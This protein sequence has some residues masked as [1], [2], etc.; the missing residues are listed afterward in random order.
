MYSPFGSPVTDS[1]C[2]WFS[3]IACFPI[4]SQAFCTRLWDFVLFLQVPVQF[5][6][7]SFLWKLIPVWDFFVVGWRWMMWTKGSLCC[8]SLGTYNSLLAPLQLPL[9]F[10]KITIGSWVRWC[11]ATSLFLCTTLQDGWFPPDINFDIVTNMVTEV[12]IPPYFSLHN[13]ALYILRLQLLV[14]RVKRERAEHNL[15][16]SGVGH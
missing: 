9:L 10:I 2:L 6:F 4:N 7:F 16:W 1:A 12:V 8:W 3:F 13:G 15:Q 5:V 11:W 14:Y